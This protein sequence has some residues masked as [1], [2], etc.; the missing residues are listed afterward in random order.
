MAV[1][2][3]LIVCIGPGCGSSSSGSSS[4]LAISSFD[5]NPSSI[6]VGQT[7]TL[8]WA[9]TGAKTVS[10]DQGIGSVAPSGTK[11]VT[12]LSTMT[13]TLTASDGTNSSKV[14]VNITVKPASAASP[15]QA[16]TA[17]SASLPGGPVI[18]SFTASPA[19]ID[20]GGN[21]ILQWSTSGATSVS[22]SPV[23]GGVDP[24]GTIEVT[25]TTST[26]YTLTATNAMGS[27]SSTLRVM[28]PAYM[29]TML[30]V[31]LNF[32]AQPPVITENDTTT[33]Y[34]SVYQANTVNIDP[35][36]EYIPGVTENV[37]RTV[38]PTGTAPVS[39]DDNL[40]YTLTATNWYG[41]T[42]ASVD[43]T[44]WRTIVM[45]VRGKP[46]WVENTTA[47]AA[48]VMPVI[49]WFSIEPATII[50]GNTSVIN[51]KTQN[52]TK[53]QL[54][55]EIVSPEGSKII[56]DSSGQ[57][58]SMSTVYTL[59]AS[60]SYGVYSVSKTLTVLGYLKDWFTPLT[61]N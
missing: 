48:S 26:A 15:G 58:D 41:T 11:T 35:N 40:T 16:N 54:N 49:T 6:T 37:S 31:I 60:N 3:V 59:R 47:L 13:Y 7:A 27:I 45:P 10:I 30:P 56:N 14:T 25:P 8:S 19:I 53:V 51:W 39:P 23:I 22:I 28:V 50:N 12:P 18:N 52:A 21:S 20:P 24:L 4:S 38:A 5:V 44:V 61:A 32:S 42:T 34:W 46:I 29:S 36:L 2:T 9:V 55:G 17:T 57:A 43:V 1:L 33:L